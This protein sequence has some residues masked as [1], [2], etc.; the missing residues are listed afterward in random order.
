MLNRR[1]KAFSVN[2]IRPWSNG[3][4][5]NDNNAS[6][7]SQQHD[8]ISDNENV[9]SSLNEMLPFFVALN[10]NQ[11]DLAL[12]LVPDRFSLNTCE[13]CLVLEKLKTG[14]NPLT[15]DTAENKA[16]IRLL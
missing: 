13:Y 7:D 4:E 16:K 2:L 6:Y 5:A 12:I 9:N 15:L 3:I 11:F 14:V 10:L 8:E 1:T